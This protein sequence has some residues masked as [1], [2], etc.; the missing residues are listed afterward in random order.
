MPANDKETKPQVDHAALEQRIIASLAAADA[1]T[2]RNQKLNSTLTIITIIGSAVTAFLTAITAA[3]GPD[4]IPGVLNWQ[5]ACSIGAVLSIITAICSGLS[6]QMDISRKLI[7]GSQCVGR[8]R[9]LELVTATRVRSVSE[10]TTEYAEV[11]R[12]Y[13]EAI[14]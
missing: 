3:Q 14:K 9:A 11:L 13:S 8:L 4:V 6:Q 7:E 1:Y 2:R 5:G 12:T 10:I